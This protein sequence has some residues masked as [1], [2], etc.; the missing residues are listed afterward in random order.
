MAVVGVCPEQGSWTAASGALSSGLHYLNLLS[1]IR[2][3]GAL[4]IAGFGGKLVSTKN[5]RVGVLQELEVMVQ[6]L[7]GRAPPGRS[8]AEVVCL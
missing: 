6:L 5:P 4:G 7:P 8:R 2:P 3:H 1:L